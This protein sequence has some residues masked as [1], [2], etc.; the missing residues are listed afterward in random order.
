MLALVGSLDSNKMVV[1]PNVRWVVSILRVKE[2]FR[3]VGTIA[4]R[5]GSG[6]LITGHVY[7]RAYFH[8]ET[9][10]GEPQDS[11]KRGF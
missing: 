3:I 9:G 2:M 7:Y 8:P 11:K 10:R 1:W 4:Q 5:E 6:L